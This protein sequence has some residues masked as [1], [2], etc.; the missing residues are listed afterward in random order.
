[1]LRGF[2][3]VHAGGYSRQAGLWEVAEVAFGAS[4]DWNLSIALT[5]RG[6]SVQVVFSSPLSFRVQD[7]GALGHYWKVRDIERAGIGTV[8]LI[9]TSEYCAEIGGQ[10]GLSES[11]RH[12]LVAGDDTCVEVITQSPPSVPHGWASD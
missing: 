3:L 8:Y 12:Y 2:R 9:G 6:E 10:T 5:R 7:E 4:S 11:L 1:M